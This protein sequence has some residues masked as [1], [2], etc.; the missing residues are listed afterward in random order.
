VH[1]RLASKGTQGTPSVLM[2]CIQAGLEWAA[3]KQAVFVGLLENVPFFDRMAESRRQELAQLMDLET[4]E[5][6]AVLFREGDFGGR[7]QILSEGALE[8]LKYVGREASTGEAKYATIATVSHVLDRP[9]VG[10]M[11]L[12]LNKPRQGTAVVSEGGVRLL[13]VPPHH[14]ETFV[15]LCPDFR[16]YLNKS[17]AQVD[18]WGEGEADPTGGITAE[19]GS[20]EEKA[21][22]THVEVG[23]QW[24]TGGG[25]GGLGQ[26]IDGERCFFAERWERMVAQ[27][28]F[29]DEA[30][31]KYAPTLSL[32]V[33]DYETRPRVKVGSSFY[34]S[35]DDRRQ[36]IKKSVKPPSKRESSRM[37]LSATG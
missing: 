4:H 37:L 3:L 33:G 13:C 32:D 36:A 26:E 28:L 21:A 31:S 9:W 6:G 29:Q 11:G 2:E 5:A 17:H 8:V 10:E 34:D 7:F 24:K 20:A 35:S 14:F 25:L 1:T 19:Q 27:L 15:A 18:K 12:W 23:V 16:M 22:I 30:Y